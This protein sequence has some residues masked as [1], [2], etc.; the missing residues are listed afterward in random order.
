M[1]DPGPIIADYQTVRVIA[2]GML[3]TVYEV[4]HTMLGQRRFAL[5]V[6][7]ERALSRWFLRF[8][9][10]NASFPCPDVPTGIVPL[11]AI[12]ETNGLPYIVM[13]LIEGDD[14]CNG[15]ADWAARSAENTAEIIRQVATTLDFAHGRDIVH[16]L[17]HPRHI[18]QEKGGT[19]R[20]IGFAEWPPQ[21]G[22][23]SCRERV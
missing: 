12:G 16:G 5:K 17:V 23:A 11:Y 10:V 6:L 8:A 9:K 3:A 21:I 7:R 14:L 18:L 20:V 13:P 1:A 22:R 4:V 19:V 2:G 15:I